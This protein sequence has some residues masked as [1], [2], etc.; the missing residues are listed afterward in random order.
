[1]S[2]YPLLTLR[3]LS[4]DGI[5]IEKEGLLEISVPL[6]DGGSIGI[7]PGHAPLIA[8]TTR[9]AIHFRAEFEE[10]SVDI[11]PGVLDI[12]DNAVIILSAGEITQQSGFASEPGS[13]TF[14]RLIRT[15]SNKLQPE[16][17]TSLPDDQNG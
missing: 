16:N 3:I 7:R 6:A 9:G 10:S 17:A 12:R 14:E 13:M 5:N 4:P 15:L 2:V 1:M 11:L 8:E